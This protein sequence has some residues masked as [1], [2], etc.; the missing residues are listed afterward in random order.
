M[1][2]STLSAAIARL[3][4]LGYVSSRA[5]PADKRERE[6]RLTDLGAEAM[7]STSVLD[8]DHVAAL[9]ARLTPA[10]RHLVSRGLSLLAQ[11]ARKLEE[12]S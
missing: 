4:D 1:A 9:V 3:V 7:A 10:E 12:R 6:L 5:S 2:P 8:T 11:A